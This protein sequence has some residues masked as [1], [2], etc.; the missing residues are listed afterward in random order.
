M[1]KK[2]TQK[3]SIFRAHLQCDSN[4]DQMYGHKSKCQ[5]QSIKIH[6]FFSWGKKA[7]KNN[8]TKTDILLQILDTSQLCKTQTQSQVLALGQTSFLFFL[9]YS[10][11]LSHPRYIEVCNF[12]TYETNMSKN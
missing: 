3:V 11:S 6:D 8:V 9:M 12:K 7:H 5:T 2:N 1:G 4:D 10:N